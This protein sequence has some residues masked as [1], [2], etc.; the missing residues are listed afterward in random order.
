MAAC[1]FHSRMERGRL[2][3]FKL[4]EVSLKRS[5]KNWYECALIRRAPIS[6][7]ASR[8]AE[9]Y[10]SEVKHK[11]LYVN[12]KGR[13][14][15]VTSVDAGPHRYSGSLQHD[16]RPFFFAITDHKTGSI[17]FMGTVTN[18]RSP[19]RAWEKIPV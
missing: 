2:P 5:W 6:A 11:L 19:E 13:S 9:I 14:A 16:D 4:K 8:S 3:R 17:L 1:S 7:D 18:R 12:E 15:A 10:I